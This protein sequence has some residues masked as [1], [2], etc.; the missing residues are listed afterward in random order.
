MPTP[1]PSRLTEY[2]RQA[3]LRCKAADKAAAVAVAEV[4][5][6]EAELR[7]IGEEL[8][9]TEAAAKVFEELRPALQR[10]PELARAVRDGVKEASRRSRRG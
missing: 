7:A 10:F 1:P 5:A 3:D 2:A 8:A 6:A 9:A 4:E